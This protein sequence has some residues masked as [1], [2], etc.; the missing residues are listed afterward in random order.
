MLWGSIWGS[1][2]HGAMQ[3]K[4]NKIAALAKTLWQASDNG[5]D[6]RSEVEGIAGMIEELAKEA[7][8][9]LEAL[10]EEINLKAMG[11]NQHEEPALSW[12]LQ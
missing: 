10:E 3:L 12:D 6:L 11:R 9:T 8:E 1:A 7:F 4:K 2:F 5:G